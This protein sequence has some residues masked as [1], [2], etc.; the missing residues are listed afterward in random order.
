MHWDCNSGTDANVPTSILSF[1]STECEGSV[2]SGVPEPHP[3]PDFYG[4]SK[5]LVDFNTL[6]LDNK[7][8]LELLFLLD[9]VLFVMAVCILFILFFLPHL[10][11]SS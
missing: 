1:S 10:Q 4:D 2:A 5:L 8:V 11:R 6:L 7:A 3:T 9:M